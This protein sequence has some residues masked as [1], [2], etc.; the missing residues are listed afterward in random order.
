MTTAIEVAYQPGKEDQ[1]SR[2]DE[3]QHDIQMK[4][5]GKLKHYKVLLVKEVYKSNFR[6]HRF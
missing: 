2:N 6:T 1:P 4:G 3:D 5:H